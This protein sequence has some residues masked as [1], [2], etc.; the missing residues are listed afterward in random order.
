[1]NVEPSVLYTR[2]FL[3][4]SPDLASRRFTKIELANKPYSSAQGK[5]LFICF[6]IGLI[7]V[8]MS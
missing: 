2:P 5:L 1:M 6:A 8:M 7:A 4:V 3:E